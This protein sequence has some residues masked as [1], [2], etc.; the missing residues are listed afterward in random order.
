MLWEILVPTI[1][2]GKPIRVRYHRVW[3]SKVRAIAGGLTILMPAKGH[4]M[5]PAGELFVERMIPVRI[6]C[7]ESEIEAIAE[8]TAKYYKQ[9]AVMF[10]LVSSRVFIRRY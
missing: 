3:D 4:W 1:M 8:M 5:S 6:A 2:D 9:E 10:Y 7:N